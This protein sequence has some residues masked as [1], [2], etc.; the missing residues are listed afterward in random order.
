MTQK[1]RGLSTLLKAIT[2]ICRVVTDFGPPLRRYVPAAR[3]AAYDAA[4]QSILAACEVV[5]TI[6]WV[7][8]GV[9][10]N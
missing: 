9:G 6:D 3:L 4:L 5:R 8:D 7:A 10:L 2:L 1:L